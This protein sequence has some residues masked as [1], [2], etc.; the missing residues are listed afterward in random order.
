MSDNSE[1]LPDKNNSSL[2]PEDKR[3]I[4]LMLK[5]LQ[6][7]LEIPEDKIKEIEKIVSVIEISKITSPYPPPELL[8]H[9][10][11]VYPGFINK[12][13]EYIDKNQ[14]Q[15]IKAQQ[16]HAEVEKLDIG[17]AEKFLE[18]S[19]FNTKRGQ[20]QA[21]IIALIGL[22]GGIICAFLKLEVLGAAFVGFPLASIISNFLVSRNSKEKHRGP[23]RKEK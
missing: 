14:E 2:T 7:E 20:W 16:H 4:G 17:I 13:I 22:T 15:R 21:F 5:Y 6:E 3:K 12:I 23:K 1:N 10:E 9:Y 18:Y 8:D 11:K 19:Y